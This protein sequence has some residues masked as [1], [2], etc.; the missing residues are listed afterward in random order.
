MRLITSNETIDFKALDYVMRTS[1]YQQSPDKNF[2]SELVIGSN[3]E[4]VFENGFKNRTLVVVLSYIGASNLMIRRY[5]MRA[6]TKALLDGGKL[7]LDYEP[8]IYWQARVLDSTS[9]KFNASYDELSITFN[10]IP[11][12][13]SNL[14]EDEL[15]WENAD[16]P[17]GVIDIPWGGNPFEFT[18]NG[19]NLLIV[20][21][22]NYPS[23]PIYTINGTGNVTLTHANGKTFTLAAI[24]GIINID[25]ELMI[26]YDNSNVNQMPKFSGDFFGLDVGDNV[27]TTSGTATLEVTKK[28]RVI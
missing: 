28:D 22:G 15:T 9:I 1:S 23:L 19:S 14:E 27:I 3:Q 20:N 11:I 2:K 8:S 10:L 24:S 21:Y 7:T 12:A 26:V 18:I 6:I 4:F 17:W 25:T 13:Y 5:N 16:I